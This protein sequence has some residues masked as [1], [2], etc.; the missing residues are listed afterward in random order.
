MAFITNNTVPSWA[1][2]ASA[3]GIGALVVLNICIYRLFFHPYAKYPGPFLAKLTSWYSV[4]HTYHG[5]LHIDI[6]E[7]HKKYGDC[8]RY[9]PNRVLINNTEG[10]KAIY[11]QGK[12]TQKAS[13]YRKVSLVPGVHPTFSMIDNQGHAKLRRL[14]SQGLSNSHVRA[15]DQELRESALL[16]ATRLGEK[17]DR[18]EPDHDQPDVTEDG[19]TASKNVASWC[20]YFTFDVMSHLVYGT[21]YD[22]LT[23]SENHWVID[24]VL[25]QMRRISFLTMLPELE[26]MR[27][28]RLLFPDARRK[29][30]RFSIKSREIM[31]ARKT[32]EKEMD[33]RGDQ[34]NKVDLFSKLLAAKDPETGEGLSDKQLWAESNLMIIA[35]SDTSSTGIAATFFYLSRNPSAYARVTKEVRSAIT[36]PEDIS[37]GP[38]LLSCTYLRACILESMRLSPPAGGAMWRQAMPGGLH[39]AGPQADLHIPGGCEI[40]TGIYALHHNEEY[41]PEPFAFRPERWLPEEVGEE[42][43]AKAHAAFDT[44]SLGPRGCP[45]KSLAMVEIP[46]ALAAVIRSYDFRKVESSLGEVGEGKG[47]FAGQ[48]QTFWAFTSLKDGPYFQFKRIES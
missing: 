16:F 34:E 2:F 40:G 4:Y 20:N 1:L 41:Y 17:L 21:S 38:K 13:A 23:N 42:A 5:D 22:L 45:G 31:E 32:K 33:Q 11:S 12:N 6:W 10:L 35:G 28:D 39:I 27:F 37:Q 18:F 47:K 8:V 25:G 48:Y 30:F 36:T 43:V 29:A 15:Y 7:C 9:A 26:D 46:F 14:V 24:G 3:V 44:F 19:W